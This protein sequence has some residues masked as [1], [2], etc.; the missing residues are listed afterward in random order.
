MAATFTILEQG[1]SGEANCWRVVGTWATTNPD[2]AVN[3]ATGLK[4][5]IHA[6]ITNSTGVRAGQAENHTSTPGT[7]ALSG[8]TTGDSGTFEA[9]GYL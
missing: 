8:V 3:I 9:V 7:I 5:V 6:N 4:A 2:T 1:P